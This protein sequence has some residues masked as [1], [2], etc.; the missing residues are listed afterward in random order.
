VRRGADPPTLLAGLDDDDRLEQDLVVLLFFA[1]PPS[2]PG[3][4]PAELL[5]AA[6]AA[7]GLPPDDDRLLEL[8]DRRPFN[9]GTQRVPPTHT[10]AS[11]TAGRRGSF[12]EGRKTTPPQYFTSSKRK[13]VC[14]KVC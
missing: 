3:V 4:S 10:A 7:A 8:P 2:R 14:G 6:A 13:L 1:W 12:P 11:L 5:A 9:A